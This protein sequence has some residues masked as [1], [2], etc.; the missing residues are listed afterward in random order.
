MRK[1]PTAVATLAAAIFLLVPAVSIAQAP[2]GDFASGSGLWNAD[3]P[4]DLAPG[5]I[6]FEAKQA[7]GSENEFDYRRQSDGKGFHAQVVCIEVD[8]N[9]QVF[10]RLIVDQ[11]TMPAVAVGTQLVAFG[12]DQN[13][14]RG[15]Q[16]DLDIAPAI[17]LRP[18]GFGEIDSDTIRGDIHVADEGAFGM[19]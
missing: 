15:D 2:T 19:H 13:E 12:A 17:G 8:A 5:S 14:G 6:G 9:N 11:S 3:D 4:G 10:M 7:A 16:F 18:C 1:T